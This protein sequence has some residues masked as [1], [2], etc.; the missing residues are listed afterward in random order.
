MYKWDLRIDARRRTARLARLLRRPGHGARLGEPPTLPGGP[1]SSDGT[2]LEEN[3]RSEAS[4][5]LTLPPALLP[6]SPRVI[7]S[8][9]LG[10]HSSARQAAR[11]NLLRVSRTARCARYNQ[12]GFRFRRPACQSF[13]QTERT[14]SRWGGFSTAVCSQMN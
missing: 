6:P 1:S 3:F 8:Y 14:V 9:R 13:S 2:V 12:P 5:N 10:S 7:S 11:A 4:L